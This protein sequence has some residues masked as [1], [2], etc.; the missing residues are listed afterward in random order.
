MRKIL[1]SF[2]IVTMCLFVAGLGF[3]LDPAAV[4]DGHVYLLDNISGTDVPDDSANDNTGTINGD[5]AIVNGVN[6]KALKFDGVDDFVGIPNTEFINA[7][8]PWT[9][10]TVMAIFNAADVSKN[11]IQCIYEEGGATRG[12]NI[13]ILAGE[14]YGGA[15][16]RAEYNW[17]G[18]WISAPI[19]SNEW[20][21]LAFVLR[22]GTA[23]VLPDKFEVWLDGDLIGKEPGGQ[24]H[25]HTA[26]NAIGA[27]DNDTIFHDGSAST[28]EGW[29]FE[30]IVDAVWIL[31]EA[32]DGA[33]LG[34]ILTSVE[35]MNK[36]TGSW[37]AIKAQH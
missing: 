12:M 5:P 35:P 23:E 22:D 26:R 7:G 3:A 31:N 30:G 2:S 16:N 24:M 25:G 6:S 17:D 11:E 37:G 20:H 1:V 14:V 28:G 15:W 9:N 4:T 18:A 34:A 8:G 27:V 33:E 32:L 10:R 29:F 19:G 36:L 13:Y 21:A